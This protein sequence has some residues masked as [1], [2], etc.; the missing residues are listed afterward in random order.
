MPATSWTFPVTRPQ[1]WPPVDSLKRQE[2]PTESRTKGLTSKSKN[3][4]VA[5][6]GS[7]AVFTGPVMPVI[8]AVLVMPARAHRYSS[9]TVGQPGEDRSI[10][11]SQANRLFICPASW[12]KMCSGKI[13]SSP[14]RIIRVFLC[15]VPPETDL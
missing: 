10:V 8:S 4:T 11:G 5:P 14:A 12:D 1:S 9:K 3:I 15:L 7:D 6:S 13:L 2:S